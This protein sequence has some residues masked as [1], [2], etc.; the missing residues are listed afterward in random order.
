[1]PSTARK[2]RQDEESVG[3]D[4]DNDDQFVSSSVGTRKRKGQKPNEPSPSIKKQKSATIKASDK[5]CA[6]SL[7]MFESVS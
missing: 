1:M 7:I 4:V 3:D 5:E 6:K 2:L